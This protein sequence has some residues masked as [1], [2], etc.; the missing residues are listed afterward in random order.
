MATYSG[1]IVKWDTAM[2]ENKSLADYEKMLSFDQEAPVK[3]LADGT[4][5][6]PVPGR[7]MVTFSLPGAKPS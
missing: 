6:Q 4:Y 5:L 2:K 1:Q 3:P 7:G